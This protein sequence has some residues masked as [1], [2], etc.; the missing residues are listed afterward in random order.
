M[1]FAASFA[2]GM[3]G[4]VIMGLISIAASP[5]G[6]SLGGCT[7]RHCTVLQA[8]Y[9]LNVSHRVEAF[10]I[11]LWL[12]YFGFTEIRLTNPASLSILIEA[13]SS[14]TFSTFNLFQQVFFGLNVVYPGLVA[15][16][17]A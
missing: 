16:L 13:A 6:L 17:T 14:L 5:F 3:F 11:E 1:I 7:S 2:V 8:F 10:D 12:H 9:T 15:P 4:F